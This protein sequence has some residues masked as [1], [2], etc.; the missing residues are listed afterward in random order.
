MGSNAEEIR[1]VVRDRYGEIAR[2]GGSCCSGSSCGPSAEEVSAGIGYDPSELA[3]APDGSNL[4]LG[5]GNPQAIAS[6]LPGE[7]V[8]DLGSGAGFDVFLAARQVGESGRVIGVDMTPDMIERARGI[9]AKEGIGNVDFRLGEIEHQPVGDGT[10]DVI[11]SNC[12]INLA[13]D[14]AAVYR[15]AF[16]VL[17]SGGRLAISDVVALAPLPEDIKSDLR[18]LAGCV[19]GALLVNDL[20]TILEEV[21]FTEVAVEVDYASKDSIQEWF[22][23][24]RLEEYVSSATI[25]AL[26][27]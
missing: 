13:A 15:D 22:P 8:V 17:R 25:R 23:G 10:A 2:S 11:M 21:G 20:E 9:A 19:A 5:C 27:P 16:R 1:K 12:V 24:R 7:T 18:A 3:A 14:K 26:K 6:L 4:G